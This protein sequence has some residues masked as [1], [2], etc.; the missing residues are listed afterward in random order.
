MTDNAA[1]PSH[2]AVLDVH[3]RSPS[4]RYF[5]ARS[6]LATRGM[7]L[8]GPRLEWQAKG[9]IDAVKDCVWVQPDI[10][11]ARGQHLRAAIKRACYIPGYV[12]KLD[13]HG[14]THGC[15]NA[16]AG[17]LKILP[18]RPDGAGRITSDPAH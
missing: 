1:R 8:G 18:V 4:G 9:I 10:G 17:Y 13:L 16:Y 14:E 7:F 6:K 3:F 2:D 12:Q 11:V 15:R 5:A